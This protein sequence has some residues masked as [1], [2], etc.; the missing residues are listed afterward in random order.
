MII[1][2]STIF[3][4]DNFSENYQW[5]RLR[6]ISRN[7]PFAKSWQVADT[8]FTTPVNLV[9]MDSGIN[10]NHIEF[11]NVYK[12]TNLFT[13]SQFKKNYNDDIGSG[14]AIASYAV[15]KNL[16]IH[17]YVNLINCKVMSANYQPTVLNLSRA[18]D[19]IYRAFQ[20]DSST[21]MIVTIGWTIP[22]NLTIEKKIQTMI[23]AGIG[24]VCA[25]GDAG[26]DVN[27]ITPAGMK[28]VITVAASDS[29]DVSAG[30]NNFSS[31]NTDF[32]TNFGNGVNLFAPGV[33]C[34]GANFDNINSYTN[35]SGTA[36]SAGYTS[37]C[38]A[39]IMSLFPNK[40]YKEAKDI[41]L[42]YATTGA[43]LLDLDQF[44]YQ[45]NLIAYNIFSVNS[46][47]LTS[48]T[49]YL[50]YVD[51]NTPIITGDINMMMNVARYSSVT[52]ELFK[53][54]LVTNDDSI[55]KILDKSI[56]LSANGEFSIVNPDIKWKTGESVK[57]FEFQ[58]AAISQSK[59]IT[60]VSPSLI[61]FA[62]NPNNS[63]NIMSD[64]S[65]ALEKADAQS[66]FATVAPLALK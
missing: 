44:E 30:F 60:F 61:F 38:L 39:S 18:L 42:E 16:G 36:V 14:T 59:S 21:P 12:K 48:S 29:D 35:N 19:A 27:I 20:K 64:L 25:A 52:N 43:M 37:G 56:S 8:N 17:Q 10:F 1:S 13:L 11:D 31:V 63:K 6:L 24:F 15:G 62:T 66:F 7:R 53:Y 65:S 33:D 34:L 49:F 3:T 32:T 51:V 58:I 9:I 41:L 40:S 4:H 5:G 55:K 57:L 54:E 2:N 22:K 23:D 50:G 28:D 26:V 45:Q 46:M 47:S